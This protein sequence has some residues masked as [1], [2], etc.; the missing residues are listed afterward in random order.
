MSKDK[1]KK[2]QLKTNRVKRYKENAILARYLPKRMMRHGF[3][4]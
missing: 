4:T 1:D 2:I 3:I